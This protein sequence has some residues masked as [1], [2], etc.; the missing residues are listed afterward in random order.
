MSKSPKKAKKRQVIAGRCPPS[1]PFPISPCSRTGFCQ[2]PGGVY[3]KT[4][5]YEDIN[6]AVASAE[7][8]TA[9]ISGWSSWLNYFDSSLPFQL[10]F[11][12]RRSRN[13]NRYKVNIP[14]QED[15][16]FNSVRTEYM[17]MLKNQIAKSNNGIERYKYVTFG[18]P[19]EDVAAA[20]PRLERVEAGCHRQL[21]TAGRPVP[22]RWMAGSVWPCCMARCI[23]AGVS[24]S[25]LRGK[26]I[27]PDGHG[28]E[29][30]YRPGQLRLPAEPD[31]PRRPDMGRG[32]LF[33]DHGVGAVG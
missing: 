9:I 20:R 11:V 2:L 27:R 21:E 12:N 1:R 6:Y 8:Q 31:F 4:L 16:R 32:V 13:A 26:D 15:D 7:D 33:A 5:E 3:T 19:A 24:R 18:I 22:A 14:A 29:G 23:P 10:S 28:D 17:E 25:A 30:L